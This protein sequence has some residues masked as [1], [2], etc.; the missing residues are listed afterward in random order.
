MKKTT[1]ALLCVFVLSLLILPFSPQALAVDPDAELWVNG[2]NVDLNEDTVT[3]EIGDGTAV[4]TNETA[5]LELNDVDITEG[6]QY[7][8]EQI[9]NQA[10][11][12]V[13]NMDLTIVLDGDNTIEGEDISDALCIQWRLDHRGCFLRL[14]FPFC[15]F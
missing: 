15:L 5:T 7:L 9:S 6:Y 10:G 14:R 1:L 3:L 4:Y 8:G 2:V 11:I 12:Y 13:R